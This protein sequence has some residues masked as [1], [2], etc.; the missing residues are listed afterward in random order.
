MRL[1]VR[2]H[3]ADG[4]GSGFSHAFIIN[5]KC[6]GDNG[7]SGSKTP[8]LPGQQMLAP[9]TAPIRV[10]FVEDSAFDYELMLKAIERDGLAIEGT[11]VEESESM[12]AALLGGLW[13]AVIADRNLP[14]F[15]S[16]GALQVLRES[17]LD[18]PFLVV[19]GDSGEEVAVEAMLA[20]AEDYIMKDRLKRLAPA[21]RRSLQAAAV[22]R[23]RATA[24]AALRA[25][26]ARLHE[27]AGHL[28]KV[29]DAERAAVAT[30][31]SEEIG[32]ALTALKFELAWLQ[33]HSQL[34]P[35]AATRVA[36]AIAL[37]EH[38]NLTAQR[39]VGNLRP[40]I[41]DQGI[42]PALEWLT[43]QF[44]QHSG[45]ET[46][47]DT[48]RDELP[49][50]EASIGIYRVCQE[51]LSNIVRHSRA[52]RVDVH[53]FAAEE[54]IHLEITDNGQGLTL[55]DAATQSFGLARMR[56]RAHNLQG[57]L[58]ISS[59]P[60]HGTTVLLSVPLS[61]SAPVGSSA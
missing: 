26:E 15:S 38:T 2:R 41:L 28:E 36:S 20:G 3:R 59:N 31:I 56:E 21:L 16:A 55:P 47:F 23:E 7:K 51:A 30:E 8:Q 33:R 17:R 61:R 10:L 50:P 53:L 45:I 42:V 4:L 22:R 32:S 34:P 29:K 12:R 48:N 44:A 18:L 1:A 40:A 52:G 35:E 11:R 60:G 46:H 54:Q 27:L 5:S 19:S 25:S 6:L 49:D 13:D 24:E 14:H 43:T 37:V 9:Q 39:V 58:D 57:S